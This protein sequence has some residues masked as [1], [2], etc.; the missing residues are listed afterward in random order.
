MKTFAS[1]RSH[2][3]AALGTVLLSSCDG[4]AQNNS[5]DLLSQTPTVSAKQE[6]KPPPTTSQLRSQAFEI[7][8][9]LT[10]ARIVVAYEHP[11]HAALV[12]RELP[13][14]HDPKVCAAMIEMLEQRVA[15]LPKQLPSLAEVQAME[16]AGRTHPEL[17][18][19]RWFSDYAKVSNLLFCLVKLGFPEG[20][21]AAE[22]TY[23]KL[24]SQW[25]DTEASRPLLNALR[26][27]MN[28]SHHALKQGTA[29]WQRSPNAPIRLS[30]L[31]E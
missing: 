1:F 23:E 18:A 4:P 2:V 27:E 30:P 19:E 3:L 8:Q 13:Y 21:A 12:I 5:P 24:A 20:I 15:K 10:N 11:K 9:I 6:S 25:G 31:N 7:A 29:K 22:N 28:H 26:T 16:I 17:W 14:Y